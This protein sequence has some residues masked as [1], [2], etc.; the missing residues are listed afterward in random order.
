MLHFNVTEHPT[1][2]WAAQQIIEAFPEDAAPRYL[3]R[4]RDGVYGRHLR[5]RVEGMGIQ[6]VLT[7]AQSPWQNPFA[8]RFIGSITPRVP[9]SH[10]R[11]R[12]AASEVGIEKILS[13]LS[14]FHDSSILG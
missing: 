12:R 14:R 7:A 5:N 2:V 13:V 10:D 9:Q 8:E 6:E 1:A 11:A 4:D 3:I